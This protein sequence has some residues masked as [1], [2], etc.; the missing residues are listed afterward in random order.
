[1]SNSLIFVG[2]I[3]IA[4]ALL[5]E[6]VAAATC[7]ARSFEAGANEQDHEVRSYFEKNAT[8]LTTLS[9]AAEAGSKFSGLP[10]FKGKPV[11]MQIVADLAQPSMIYHET[12]DTYLM[13][14]QPGKLDTDKSSPSPRTNAKPIKLTDDERTTKI[15][16][17]YDI[18]STRY[19]GQRPFDFSQENALGRFVAQ[20]AKLEKLTVREV[21][22]G[23]G[24]PSTHDMPVKSAFARFAWE[25][26][27]LSPPP[28]GKSRVDHRRSEG[29]RVLAPWTTRVGGIDPIKDM[30]D[31]Q[32]VHQKVAQAAFTIARNY[33]K[34]LK[35]P[36][37][38]AHTLSGHLFPTE[39]VA[40][41]YF[42][43]IAAK[44]KTPGDAGFATL[45]KV[46]E[47]YESKLPGQGSRPSDA[48]SQA[49]Y[50]WT[51][52]ATELNNRNVLPG[53]T[54]DKNDLSDF[55]ILVESLASDLGTDA[56]V[57]LRALSLQPGANPLGQDGIDP[58][59]LVT[60]I[61]RL[62]GMTNTIATKPGGEGHE[63]P[64][65]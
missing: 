61:E 6:E 4:A 41:A 45:V 18:F 37:N 38:V 3:S 2:V 42:A 29:I 24:H 52:L 39:E 56:A 31:I 9:D 11:E 28:G 22:L 34:I 43:D 30:D 7:A 21:E 57:I 27:H 10:T 25:L 62:V 50:N 20:I 60:R 51:I 63:A 35:N 8:I 55:P 48:S 15:K 32:T 5:G 1:M 19:P 58:K 16:E 46:I 47:S 33:P 14:A 53:F 23:L 59:G 17:I 36:G 65:P 44:R 64:K 54:W 49:S 40:R 13:L 26:K 12:R